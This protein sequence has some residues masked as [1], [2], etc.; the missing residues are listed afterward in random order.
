M[1]RAIGSAG[2]IFLLSCLGFGQAGAPRPGFEVA[3]IKQNISGDPDA[4]GGLI[5]GGQLSVRNATLKTLLGF[6][7]DPA[8]QRYRDQFIVGAPPWVDTDRFDIIAKAP[9]NLPARQC[10]FSNFCYPDG[11]VSEMLQ[12]LLEQRFKMKVHRE[13]RPTDAYAMV[14]DKGGPKLQKAAGSGERLCRRL[15]PEKD[16]PARKGMT[17]IEG[18]FLC[19]NMSMADLAAFL[20]DMAGAYF[21]KS[22][23]DLTGLKGTYDF[24]LSW[25]GRAQIEEGGLTVFEAA[26]KQ[27]GLKLE[28]RKVPVPVTVIDHIEKLGND[29]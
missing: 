10:F 24:R 23:V 3:D 18:G 20:P 21:D 17:A 4:T 22:V 15:P 6:A 28:S 12:V 26:S 8:H 14:L 1:K 13:Q 5:A 7:Y 27:L 11:P 25:V 16:D 2:V 9:A 19:V 29:N